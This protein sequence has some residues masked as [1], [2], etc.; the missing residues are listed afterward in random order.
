M[1]KEIII[2]CALICLF[3]QV[4]FGFERLDYDVRSAGFGGV[5]TT[6]N[7]GMAGVGN[8]AG[9]AHVVAREAGL[10]RGS[11]Y[12]G[13]VESQ[14]LRIVQPVGQLGTFAINFSQYG[15]E[16]AKNKTGSVAFGRAF[17]DYF[18]AGVQV[19][20]LNVEDMSVSKATGYSA[21]LGLV[22]YL[23]QYLQ[24]G[25]TA[26]NLGGYLQWD[27]LD[28]PKREELAK[29]SRIGA[30]LALDHNVLIGVDLKE[31]KGIAIGVETC[32][33]SNLRFRFGYDEGRPTFGFGCTIAERILTDYAFVGSPLGGV[34]M[35]STSV[36]F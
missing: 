10:E 22:L 15:T 21:D 32:P 19:N 24:V 35:L 18:A 1:R 36:R 33:D 27:G 25:Y 5:L 3:S 23:G 26:A 16:A 7:N 9:L 17:G 11:I 2:F 31:N 6:G 14:A 20:R 29:S 12:E 13:A 28:S 34:H 8:P 30:C 4:A